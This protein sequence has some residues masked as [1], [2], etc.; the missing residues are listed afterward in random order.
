MSVGVRVEVEAVLDVDVVRPIRALEQLP[1][2]AVEAE[3]RQRAVR[4]RDLHR[5]EHE[6]LRRVGAV[7]PDRRVVR[8]LR[9][10]VGGAKRLDGR[11]AGRPW[12]WRPVAVRGVARRA[13]RDRLRDPATARR[14]RDGQSSHQNST[15]TPKSDP[16][17]VV[18]FLQHAVGHALVVAQQRV[19]EVSRST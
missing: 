6:A 11:R 12:S 5:A 2:L 17:V 19:V 3:H 18:L 14:D 7:D 16:P 1:Q 8:I 10:R 9:Q 13:R 15:F 4:R